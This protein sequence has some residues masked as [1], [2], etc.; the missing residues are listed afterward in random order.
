MSIC[1]VVS[2]Q[3]NIRQLKAGLRM[4]P[5]IAALGRRCTHMLVVSTHTY[6]CT[7]T[8]THTHARTHAHTHA[9][10]HAHTQ[11]EKHP[12]SLQCLL[13]LLSP[14]PQKHNVMEELCDIALSDPMVST[15]KLHSLRA[16]DSLLDYPQGLE[17]FIGWSK[18]I[19]TSSV[20]VAPLPPTPYQHMI[21]FVLSQPVRTPL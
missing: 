20:I 17:R 11:T 18:S 3:V 2:H 15:I 14:S 13:L 7:H 4:V 8:R 19:S 6:A 10:T 16:L 9:R 12:T 21:N 1:C 5:S